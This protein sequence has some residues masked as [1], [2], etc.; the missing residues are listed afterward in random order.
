MSEI[1]A[2]SEYSKAIADLNLNKTTKSIVPEL[3]ED[4][5]QKSFMGHLKESIDTV[6]QMQ[7]SADKMAVSVSTGKTENLH[8]TMLALSQAELGFNLMVQVRNRA[9]EAY[10]EIMRMPV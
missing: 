6:D 1:L 10:Q 5:G 8:E 7:K 4:Q 9:L 3:P 2:K